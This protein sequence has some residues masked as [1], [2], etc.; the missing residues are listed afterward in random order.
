MVSPVYTVQHWIGMA[1]GTHNEAPVLASLFGIVLVLE[2][3]LLLGLAAVWTRRAAGSGD[4]SLLTVGTRFAYAL[5]PMGVGI[6]LAHYAFHFFTGLWTVI[7]VIQEALASIG[8]TL[9]GAPNWSL[10]GLPEMYV[11]PLEIGFLSL[12]MLGSVFVAYRIA[13]RE[14]PERA[15]STAV[16]W[17]MVAALLWIASLWLLNQPMEMRGSGMMMM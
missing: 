13:Q 1:I 9:F 6:W 16:P 8:F 3:A 2:P 11:A 4:E 7:P 15:V 10:V 12:G 17:A 14:Y 5:I